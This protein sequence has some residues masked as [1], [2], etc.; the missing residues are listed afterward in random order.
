[1]KEIKYVVVT[2][3]GCLTPI[4]SEDPLSHA[5]LEGNNKANSAG[6]VTF[7]KQD[8]HVVVACYGHSHS[9]GISANEDRDEQLIA[10][11]LNGLSIFDDKGKVFVPHCQIAK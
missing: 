10:R 8:A 7:E 5:E 4:I 9:L 3:M 1:M 6:F 2:K 11:M